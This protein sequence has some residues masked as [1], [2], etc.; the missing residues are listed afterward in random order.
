MDTKQTALRIEI[1]ALRN[2]REHELSHTL[3]EVTV[4]LMLSH[5]DRIIRRKGTKV[6]KEGNRSIELVE[7][8]VRHA[9]IIEQKIHARYAGPDCTNTALLSPEAQA[10]NL[11]V[12]RVL[13][14][15]PSRRHISHGASGMPRASLI[16]SSRTR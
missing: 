1:E 7:P 15:S 5:N 16:K 2:L 10:H 12:S 11:S 3:P 8:G 9:E 6:C 13:Q 14:Q 4:G